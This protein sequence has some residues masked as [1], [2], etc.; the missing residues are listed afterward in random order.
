MD[1]NIKEYRKCLQLEECMFVNNN[2]TRLITVEW[3]TLV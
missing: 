2:G 1:S 3:G